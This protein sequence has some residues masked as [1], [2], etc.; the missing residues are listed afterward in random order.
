MDTIV[1]NTAVPT[2][3]GAPFGG[4]F[5]AGRVRIGEDMFAIIL[6]PK[7]DGE[8]V[9]EQLLDS[10]ADVPGAKSFFDGKANT[11]AL[12]EA[13]SDLAKW[14]QDLRIGGF[15]DWYLPS[16][17]ELEVCYR[18]FKPTTEENYCYCGD[19]P[20]S[21][22]PGY[23]YSR[24]APAQTAVTAFQAG[25]AEAFEAD[26]Y[27]WSSTQSAGNEASAWSQHFYYGNQYHYHKD[28]ELRARAVRRLKI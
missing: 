9:D 18:A 25:G 5:Y 11:A 23:A 8:R 21:V 26:D 2:T 4:G 10:L 3:A 24:E 17:D 13:G 16:R 1:S 15:D 27:Y 6:A 20:S 12:A 14:T 22:P 19:N 28:Y 7:S